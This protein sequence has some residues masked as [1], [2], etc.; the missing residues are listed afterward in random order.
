[1]ETS[2]ENFISASGRRVYG[3]KDNIYLQVFCQYPN[4]CG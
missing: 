1:M 3:L 4:Q 2:T